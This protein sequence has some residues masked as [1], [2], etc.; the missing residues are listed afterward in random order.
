MAKEDEYGRV[1][2]NTNKGGK[3]ALREPKEILDEMKR[4]DKEST[5]ILKAIRVLV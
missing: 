4:L 3:A 1:V 5:D 2:K